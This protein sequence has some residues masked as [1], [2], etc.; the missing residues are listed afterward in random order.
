MAGTK[1]SSVVTQRKKLRGQ[2]LQRFTE[3]H[4]DSRGKERASDNS[5]GGGGR[6]DLRVCGRWA[7]LKAVGTGAS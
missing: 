6:A 7:W 5:G 4:G 1:V 3:I 2:H